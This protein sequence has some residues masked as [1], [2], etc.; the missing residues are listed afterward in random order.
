MTFPTIHYFSAGLDKVGGFSMSSA[1]SQLDNESTLELAVKESTWG[2]AH[3]LHTQAEVGSSVTMRVG[4]DFHYPNRMTN[5]ATKGHNLLLVAGGVGV[6]P[7]AS[8][9]THAAADAQTAGGQVK[10]LYSA[11][12]KDELIFRD[13]LDDIAKRKDFQVK[14]F[15]TR[16]ETDNDICHGRIT[17]DH[18]RNEVVA[19]ASS[20]HLPTF[21]YI[22]GPTTFIQDTNRALL[23]LNMPKSN[24][25]FELWW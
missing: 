19:L 12:T 8:I 16:E 25:F 10:L 24:I 22:C 23:A 15:V 4:G 13:R 6:N 9:F 1:P 18:L 20:N 7:L 2:P 21:C 11:K 5:G 17:P 3:W 14:Y